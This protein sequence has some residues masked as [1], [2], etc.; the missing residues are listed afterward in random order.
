MRRRLALLLAATAAISSCG[1]GGDVDNEL[2]FRIIQASPDT[3]LVNF[4][5]DGVRVRFNVDFKGGFGKLP[6]TPGSYDIAVEAILPGPDELIIDMPATHLSAGKEYTYIVIGKDAD[7][8]VEM[9]EF[10]SPVESIPAGNARVQLAHAAPDVG[11]VDIYFTAPGDILPAATPIAQATYGGVP[12]ARQLVPVGNYLISVTPAG[13]PDTVLYASAEF[14]IQDGQ[15]LLLVAVKNTATDTDSVPIS[16]V[17]NARSVTAEIPDADLSSDLRVVHVSPDAPALD[18]IDDRGTTQPDDDDPGYDPKADDVTLV[19]GLTYLGNSGYFP[20]LSGDSTIRAVNPAEPATTLFSF[21]W[22]NVP[23][24][25]RTV[26]AALLLANINDLTLAD[27]IR[28]VY[29][30]GQ[31]RIVNAAPGSG[32]VDVYFLD[33]ETPIESANAGLFNFGLGGAT[34]HL[35]LVPDTYT[36]TF[37]A[38][39]DKTTVLATA[40]V[41]ATAG[42]AQTVILVDAVR[43]DANSNGKPPAVLLIDDLAT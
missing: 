11:P 28:S 21:P 12:G 40:E 35:A 14:A 10:E 20:G 39:G 31:L 13:M 33:A 26:L 36:V 6:V 7:D 32:V 25:R 4:I 29:A 16:L 34:N 5:V 22:S 19:S 27:D 2:S 38:A 41:A 8:S 15:D 37:T 42:T 1:G 23:G 3:P 17:V 9:L 24:R 30:E 18:I 43:V